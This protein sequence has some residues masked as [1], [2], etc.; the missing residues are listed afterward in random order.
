MIYH[1]QCHKFIPITV[2]LVSLDNNMHISTP[3]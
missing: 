1:I 3:P 2:D